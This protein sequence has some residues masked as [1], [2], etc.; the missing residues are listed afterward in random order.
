M[1]STRSMLFV[2]AC[3]LLAVVTGCALTG[4][5]S[6][7]ANVGY[8]L[9]GEGPE[10]VVVLH[11]WLGD[12][13]NYEPV[14]PYLD[15]DAFQFAFVDLRGYGDSMDIPG[16]FT[17][18]EAARDVLSVADALGWRSFHI[19]GH[20]MTGMVVQKVAVLATSRVKSIV[21]TTPVHAGG[22]QPDDET[23]AFFAQVARSSEPMAQAIDLLTGGQLSPQWQ[24]FKVQR[25]MARSTESARLGYLEM[26]AYED[27]SR[28]VDG[29]GIPL[30]VVLGRND[31]DAF[32]PPVIEQTFGQW[33]E[34]IEIT[35][36]TDA[37]HYPMQETPALYATRVQAFLA[38]QAAR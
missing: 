26:F 34:N 4:P 32:R 6:R 2:L 23:H 25:A 18:D 5:S 33:Y 28:Q 24:Q 37:G 16:R 12:R 21:A 31:L 27:F 38:R 17:S 7:T 14:H 30:L 15:T 10:K 13:T 9:L 11:D 8:A 22:M 35:Q 29:I 3:G 36:I 19:V 20:S 1:R